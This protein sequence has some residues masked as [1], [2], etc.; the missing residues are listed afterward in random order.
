MRGNE[1]R[2]SDGENL[3]IIEFSIPMRGNECGHKMNASTAAAFSIPMRGN[4]LDL[5]DAQGTA[6]DVFDPHEG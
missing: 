5:Q 1:L 2:R 3:G 6:A 4:E